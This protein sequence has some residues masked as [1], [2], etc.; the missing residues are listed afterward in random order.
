MVEVSEYDDILEA[1][2]E[3]GDDSREV[4]VK[5]IGLGC[6]GYREE[7]SECPVFKFLTDVKGIDGI[8]RVISDAVWVDDDPI[9]EPERL[10]AVTV[11][12]PEQVR[13]FVREFDNGD[14]PE[15]EERR[16]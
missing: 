8:E 4:G 11:P 16:P 9:E 2:A 7:G 10:P 14:W 3:L 12:L 5:L 13:Q 1:L 6:T 15:L